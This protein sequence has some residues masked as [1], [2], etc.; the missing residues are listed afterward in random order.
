M[1]MNESIPLNEQRRADIPT[2]PMDDP[3]GPR[4]R[5]RR[6]ENDLG[7][8]LVAGLLILVGLVLLANQ[9]GM[10]PKVVGTDVWD[11]IMLGVGALLLLSGFARVVSSSYGRHANGRIIAGLVLCGLGISAIF[12]ISSTL[13]WPAALIVFG[14][15]LFVRNLAY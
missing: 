14:L 10:L 15:Y 6:H 1:V 12:G 7:R 13:L 3:W 8:V 2:P 11:W 9:M 5:H 4:R